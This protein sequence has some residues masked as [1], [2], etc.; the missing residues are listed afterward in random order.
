MFVLL[1]IRLSLFWKRYIRL[2]CVITITADRVFCT[3]G[4]I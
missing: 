3:V 2:A 4:K 1:K